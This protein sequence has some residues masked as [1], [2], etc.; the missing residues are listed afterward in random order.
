[1]TLNLL[2]RQQEELVA[3]GAAIAANCTP[4]LRSH[5]AK[6][7]DVGLTLDQLKAAVAVGQT[8]KNMPIRHVD[9]ALHNLLGS[10]ESE[11]SPVTQASCCS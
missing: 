6:A 8:V 4:C 9:E 3:V 5:F 7:L 10:K 11:R 1:M 2:S